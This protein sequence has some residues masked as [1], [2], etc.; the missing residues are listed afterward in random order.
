MEHDG[1]RGRRRYVGLVALAVVLVGLATW[2]MVAVPTPQRATPPD[3][4]T[5]SRNLADATISLIVSHDRRGFAVWDTADGTRRALGL[6]SGA[7]DVYV[8]SAVGGTGFT[9]AGVAGGRG[10]DQNYSP[11][12][13]P[14]GALQDLGPAVAVGGGVFSPQFTVLPGQPGRLHAEPVLSAAPLPTG[15]SVRE[16]VGEGLDAIVARPA[17]RAELTDV[18]V[19]SPGASPVPIAAG[20]HLLSV[21]DRG[22]VAWVDASCPADPPQC[23]LHVTDAITY[24]TIPGHRR[25]RIPAECTCYARRPG[26]ASCRPPGRGK[27]PATWRCS[28]NGSP[29]AG[30]SFCMRW[31]P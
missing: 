16:L 12:G 9:V 20:V 15:W 6:P 1:R 26:L 28:V 4:A 10:F 31:R 19:W 24:P 21:A 13:A 7:A 3:G 22:A 27:A 8:S 29:P 5:P 17:R 2:R 11:A 23:L 25:R 14:L 18:A 30:P